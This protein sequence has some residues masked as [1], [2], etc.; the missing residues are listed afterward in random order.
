M[1]VPRYVFQYKY[2]YRPAVQM[3]QGFPEMNLLNLSR[4]GDVGGQVHIL[5]IPMKQMTQWTTKLLCH[6]VDRV[7][8]RR[9]THT[10]SGVSKWQLKAIRG[11]LRRPGLESGLGE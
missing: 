11:Q 4:L 9:Q 6:A 3:V 5:D 8:R 10:K 2:T 1:C 7:S